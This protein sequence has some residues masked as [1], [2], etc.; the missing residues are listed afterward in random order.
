LQSWFR[1]LRENC[2]LIKE[3]MGMEIWTGQVKFVL[4]LLWLFKRG[5]RKEYESLVQQREIFIIISY[6]DACVQALQEQCPSSGFT[7]LSVSGQR[8][9]L[10]LNLGLASILVNWLF[11]KVEI[12]RLFLFSPS[13][14]I[15]IAMTL[16]N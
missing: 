1:D 9:D 2:E 13:T 11:F 16:K 5:K 8:F 10:S 12:Y 7:C 14:G 15:W 4:S 3:R 6:P